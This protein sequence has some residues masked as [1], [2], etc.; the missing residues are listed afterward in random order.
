M[1][2]KNGYLAGPMRGYP[3]FNF[4]AFKRAAEKLRKK[5]WTIFNPAEQDEA[6]FGIAISAPNTKGSEAVAAKRL[7][8]T[9]MELTRNCFLRDT[10]WICSTADAILLMPGWSKSR[11]ARAE[12]AL[13]E[14]IGLKVIKLRKEDVS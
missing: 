13:G 3:E 2:S 4:P 7:G 14:A 10:Q 11:G 5:G 6:E 12:K 8:M 9:G 1:A